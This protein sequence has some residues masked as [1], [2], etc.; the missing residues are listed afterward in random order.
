MPSFDL[1]SWLGMET[2]DANKSA[3]ASLSVDGLS[4]GQCSMNV[5]SPSDKEKLESSSSDEIVKLVRCKQC[6]MYFRNESKLEEHP[7]KHEIA[8]GGGDNP[9]DNAPQLDYHSKRKE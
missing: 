4:I 5:A 2:G 1:F 9:N 3:D 6:G 8:K 7:R